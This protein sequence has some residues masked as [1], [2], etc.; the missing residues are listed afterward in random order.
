MLVNL[1][2]N[3][4]LIFRP[5]FVQKGQGP[6]LLDWAYASD[7]NWD[8]FHSNISSSSEGVEISDTEGVEKF[9]INVR[10]NVEGFG[11]I[12][13]TADNGGEFYQLPTQS[14]KLV[15]NLNYELAKSS[16]YPTEKITGKMENTLKI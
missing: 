10:W 8:A 16:I 6:H 15:L 7:E 13:I 1:S 11:Y 9:G 5:Y 2:D 3:K 14:D 12:S 4:K